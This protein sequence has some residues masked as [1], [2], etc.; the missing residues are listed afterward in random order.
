MKRYRIAL[1]EGLEDLKELLVATGFEIVPPGREMQA[2]ITIV[3]YE[4]GE[5]LDDISPARVTYK[6]N[7][8][9]KRILIDASNL[10]PEQVLELI[11]MDW[12]KSIH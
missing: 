5:E 2:E 10:T 1:Q 12:K 9:N 6:D 4:E 3:A 7:E 11:T 8:K